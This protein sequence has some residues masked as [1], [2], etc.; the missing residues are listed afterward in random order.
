MTDADL[1]LGSGAD[2]LDDENIWGDI[3]FEEVAD[4]PFYKPDDTYRCRITEAVQRKT[5]AGNPAISMTYTILRGEYETQR[6]QEFKTFPFPWQLKGYK[7]KEDLE[8]EENFDLKLKVSANRQMS[9]IKQRMRDFGFDPK[10]MNRIKPKM[11]LALPPMDVTMV[12]GKDN[13][14]NVRGVKLVDPDSE[15]D[16][17]DPLA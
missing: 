9:F 5:Q 13:R 12:H 1:E 16:T 8:H 7:T 6:I 17:Y 14:E 4:D 2:E 11:L 15:D 3:D 10:E